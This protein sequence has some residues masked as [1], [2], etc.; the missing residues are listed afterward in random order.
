MYEKIECPFLG[1]QFKSD[2]VGGLFIHIR[3]KHPDIYN[4]DYCPICKKYFHT[5]Q[6]LQRHSLAQAIRGSEP[7]LIIWYLI[8]GRQPCSR[9][10]GR[11]HRRRAYN[12][13]VK[14]G[15]KIPV[16]VRTIV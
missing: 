15:V 14:N 12:L 16:E 3:A 13:L 8:I 10:R 1:C 2:N 5:R 9:G 7:H 11:Q 4:A 6:A